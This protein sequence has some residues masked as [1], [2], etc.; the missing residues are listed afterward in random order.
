[1]QL[2]VRVDSSGTNLPDRE[3]RLSI[4]AIDSAG[5]GIDSKYGHYH[6][7]AGG[8]AKPAGSLSQ[9][10]V[11]TGSTRVG[12]LTYRSGPISGPVVIRAEHP[13]AKPAVDTIDVRVPGLVQLVE[14]P[15]FDTIGPTTIHPNTHWLT[16]G[17]HARV[18][19]LARIF[20]ENHHGKK[21]AYNDGSLQFGGK[22]DLHRQWGNPDPECIYKHPDGRM[23]QYSQGCHLTHRQGVD[24]D[25]RTNTLTSEEKNRIRTRW[26]SLAKLVVKREGDHYHLTYK[27]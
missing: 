27:Q 24:L 3:V 8:A 17:M 20:Y 12:T 22:F 7:G 5:A 13:G 21:L 1:L 15:T 14:G 19:E 26:G 9:E 4:T 25:L 11:N 16:E 2:E 23:I 10:I 18:I 6:H